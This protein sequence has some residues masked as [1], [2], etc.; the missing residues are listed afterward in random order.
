MKY[1]IFSVIKSTIKKDQAGKG[2]GL[3]Y[4]RWFNFLSGKS[5]KASSKR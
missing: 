1:K 4:E 3:W 5:G 2:D